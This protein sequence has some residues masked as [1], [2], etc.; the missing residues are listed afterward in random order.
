MKLDLED[1]YFESY[2]KNVE[3]FIDSQLAK[4][5]NTQYINI[6]DFSPIMLSFQNLLYEVY[7]LYFARKLVLNVASKDSLITETYQLF[8]IDS[9]PELLSVIT[10]LNAGKQTADMSSN[11]SK[12]PSVYQYKDLPLLVGILEFLHNK[13]VEADYIII[14]IYESCRKL[15]NKHN[16]AGITKT[17]FKD[18][19]MESAAKAESSAEQCG[20]SEN[21]IRDAIEYKKDSFNNT[22]IPIM[23]GGYLN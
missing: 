16:G 9:I 17:E 10:L 1:F 11:G 14:S 4:I 5:N 19:I 23:S 2:M 8:T 21:V 15:S 18:I 3:E 7:R 6:Y 13:S 12:A 22:N 20:N